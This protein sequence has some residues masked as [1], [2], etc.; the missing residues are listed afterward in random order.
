MPALTLVV[1]ANSMQI[2]RMTQFDSAI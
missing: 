2:A 1:I